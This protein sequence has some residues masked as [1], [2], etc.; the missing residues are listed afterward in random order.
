MSI[1]AAAQAFKTVRFTLLAQNTAH[2][3]NSNR[4]TAL[5]DILNGK[6]TVHVPDCF[7]HGGGF[8]SLRSGSIPHPAFEFL[9]RRLKDE[10]QI[11]HIMPRI[12]LS[13]VTSVGTQFQC[14]VLTLLVFLDDPFEADVAPHLIAQVVALQQQEQPGN[15]AVA[16]AE[17]MDAEKIQIECRQGDQRMRPAFP[18]AAIPH[19]Q[20]FPHAGGGPGRFD[21][22]E[23]Y[24]FPAVGKPLDD[25]AVFILEFTG[26]PYVAPCE[27]M[28]LQNCLF[29]KG[30]C[31]S[32]GMDE[33]E[34]LPVAA[35]LFLIPVMK[36]LFSQDYRLDAALIHG[37]AFDA[38]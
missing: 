22:S 36:Q 28:E 32:I 5:L 19:I 16:V 1:R 25:I 31:G 14:L 8:C 4:W 9:I 18:H 33:V 23:A 15:A 37:N 20:K 35:D 26:I 30:E 38:V 3:V 21:R 24:P 6:V 11:I 2:Q 27:A 10:Q 12:L 7:K 17:R 34:R 29:G 13:F